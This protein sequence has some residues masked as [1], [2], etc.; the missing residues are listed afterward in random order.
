MAKEQLA[1]PVHPRNYRMSESEGIAMVRR[2]RESGLSANR[3]CKV[4]NVGLHRLRYWTQRLRSREIQS[5]AEAPFVVLSPELPET[6]NRLKE[7]EEA[8]HL[9]EITVGE[10]ISIRIPAQSGHLGAVLRTV[11]EIVE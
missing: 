3:Y 2:W 9:L 6:S 1:P 11:K 5:R 7:T 4:H 8:A 10:H